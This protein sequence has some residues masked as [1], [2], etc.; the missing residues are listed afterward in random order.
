M[1]YDNEGECMDCR[2]W[3]IAAKRQKARI[4]ELEEKAKDRG[5]EILRLVGV[6]SNAENR[7]AELEEEIAVS[8]RSE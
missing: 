5:R 6:N 2:G 8:L 3:E 1:L 4:A 7:I